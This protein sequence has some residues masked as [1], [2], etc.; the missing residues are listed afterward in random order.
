MFLGGAVVVCAAGSLVSPCSAPRTSQRSAESNGTN[1]EV[2]TCQVLVR[3]WVLSECSYRLNRSKAS[4]V[5]SAT[6]CGTNRSASLIDML[7]RNVVNASQ[8]RSLLCQGQT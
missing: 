6:V 2:G 5:R 3:M 8:D 1:H 4:A 7:P